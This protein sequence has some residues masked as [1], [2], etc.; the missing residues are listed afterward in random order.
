MGADNEAKLQELHAVCK[1]VMEFLR[2]HYTEH[3]VV[4]INDKYADL[5]K[6]EIAIGF[7]GYDD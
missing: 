6:T 1:P 2:K 5:M 7:S 3:E 4:I